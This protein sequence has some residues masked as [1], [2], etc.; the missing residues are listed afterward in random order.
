MKFALTVCTVFVVGFVVCTATAEDDWFDMENCAI[1]KHMAEHA[2]IMPDI[3]WEM[4][5][6]EKGMITVAVIPEKHQAIMK[7]AHKKMK[8]TIAKLEAGEKMDLC[9]FCTSYGSLKEAG[10]NIEEFE[11]DGG[12]MITLVT[13]ERPELIEKIHQHAKKSMEEHK[14][15]MHGQSGD[16]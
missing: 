9:G 3:K 8:K 6:T 16:K 11:T 4:T 2:H 13:A 5:A 10:A 14:K 1:C 15:M 12:I 7:D